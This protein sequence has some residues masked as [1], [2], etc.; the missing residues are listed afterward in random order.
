MVALIV[1]PMSPVQAGA[2]GEHA[3]RLVDSAIGLLGESA[4]PSVVSSK[5][6]GQDFSAE[7]VEDPSD[8]AA[9]VAHIRLCPRRVLLY[10]G[11]EFTLAPL[12]LDQDRQPVHGVAMSWDSSDRAVATVT[13]A[14]EVTAVAAGRAML[15]VHTGVKRAQAIIEVREGVRPVLSDAES[16]Q[17]HASDCED[18]ESTALNE[19]D[20]VP[21]LGSVFDAGVPHEATRNG[22]QPSEAS[23]DKRSDTDR[24]SSV[25][26]AAGFANL[27][28]TGSALGDNDNGLKRLARTASLRHAGGAAPRAVRTA[29]ASKTTRAT[30]TAAS[31]SARPRVAPA[32]F[33]VGDPIDGD[34]EDTFA[35]DAESFTNALGGGRFI[36]QEEAEAGPSKTRRQLA[37][38]NYS[39]SAP[40][41]AMGGRDIG[42][43]LAMNYNGRLW[44]KD[45]STMTFNYNKGWPAAGWSLGYGRIIKNYDNT[46]FDNLSGVGSTNSSGNFLFLAPDGS[47]VH[48]QALYN[49]TLGKWEHSTNDGTFLHMS[50]QNNIVYP[51]GTVVKFGDINNRLLPNTIKTTDGAL[52]TVAYRP[53]TGSFKYRWAIDHITDTL[54]RSITFHYYSDTGYPAD[55]A[56][57]KP[58]N[59]LAAITAADFSGGERTLVKIEYQNI[60]LSYNFGSMTVSGPSNNSTLSVVKRIYYPQSGRGYLFLDY[61]TYG[62]AR[63]VSMRTDMTGAGGAITDGTE[64]GCTKHYYTTIDAADPYGRNQSGALNDSPQYTQRKEWWQGKTDNFGNPDSNPTVYTYARTIVGTTEADT[65]TYD[66]NNIQVVTTTDNDSGS[67]SYGKVLTVEHKRITPAA[68]LRKSVYTYVAGID[69]GIQI[70]SVETFDE[71][72]Q[73][74]PIK[75]AY[76]YGSYGR[77]KNVYEYGYRQSG[78]YKVQRRTFMNYK[79]TQ[80]LLDLN[81]KQLVDNVKVYD[82][83]NNTNDADDLEV[84]RTQYTYDNYA[85][86]GGLETYGLAPGSYPPNH[87]D[88]YDQNKTDRGNV[89][90]VTTWS[91]FSPDVTTTR[92]TKYDIFGNP[93]EADV[94]CC[95]VKAWTFASS[96]Y[97]SQPVSARDG[98]TAGPN[99]TTS[100]AYN[101][102]TGMVTQVTDQDGLNTTLG[103]DNA[104]RLQTLTAPG[105]A[106]TTTEFD[107]DGNGNDQLAYKS[108]VTYTD[109]VGKTITS[110]SWFD[111]AGRVL[112]S[113][114]G[115][116]LSPTSFDTVAAVYDSLGRQLKQSNPYAGDS[117]GNGSPAYWT[118]NTYD[119]LSRV[120]RVT[121]P[122]NQM[123]QT[124]YTGSAPGVGATVVV[125]DQVGRQRKNEVDGLGRVKNVIEQNP[126]TGLLDST[127]YLTS[128]TYD[129]LDNLKTV[130]Q[131]GQTRTF[132]YDGLSRLTSQTTPEAGTVTFTYTSF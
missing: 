13:S 54:G 78:I 82:G 106:I 77:V 20:T 90:G 118:T 22:S 81:M 51:D 31:A 115:A 122:D 5:N 87:S 36:A 29:S 98:S 104:W 46:G 44:N 132:V 21:V 33:L 61:S 80:V 64:I 125:T 99:L 72:V 34:S 128:Y 88:T 42:V 8:R 97:Y 85:I 25:Q 48:F 69:G 66:N 96:N 114:T 67:L 15:T 91:K 68:T 112:R 10:V 45:G 12:A 105:G 2:A 102:N 129:A 11:E 9:R 123:I 50:F 83:L 24:L 57:G 103:Y 65:V 126:A 17:E 94:S 16:D 60:T 37:S 113:G 4:S 109:G 107:K 131:G 95:T 28:H 111:G 84:A 120:T 101:F 52:V 62:M 71:G 30:R 41:V 124:L 89:T 53:K 3:R 75:V 27:S 110:K 116:G 39:F 38:Y 18:P 32:P 76:N 100:Y 130:N 23:E 49:S 19:G 86:K 127:N 117:S 59:A 35:G 56:N 108:K 1:A 73:P 79:D 26:S 14:G 55:D 7:R 70:E 92:Y 93:V 121:L 40:V 43:G 63:R 119:E 47:R 58:T 6:R 74:E